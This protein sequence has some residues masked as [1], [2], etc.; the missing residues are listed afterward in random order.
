M[1]CEFCG[2]SAWGPCHG[3]RVWYCDQHGTQSHCFRCAP[4]ASQT[5]T[6][7]PWTDPFGPPITEPPLLVEPELEMDL[8]DWETQRALLFEDEPFV[9]AFMNESNPFGEQGWIGDQQFFSV[10]VEQEVRFAPTPSNSTTQPAFFTPQLGS[11]FPAQSPVLPPQ[12]PFISPQLVFTSPPPQGF[13]LTSPAF[14]GP[15][16]SQPQSPFGLG[17]GGTPQVAPRLLARGRVSTHL[18]EVGPCIGVGTWNLHGLNAEDFERAGSIRAW[19]L[20][21]VEEVSTALDRLLGKAGALGDDTWIEIAGHMSAVKLDGPRAGLEDLLGS[22]RQAVVLTKKEPELDGLFQP[23][24]HCRHILVHR[25]VGTEGR[26]KKI[27]E[28]DR[29]FDPDEATWRTHPLRPLALAVSKLKKVLNYSLI[30][31]Q[32]RR[33]F[34]D[35]PWLDVM[36]L[37]EVRANGITLLRR[38]IEAETGL[39]VASGPLIQGSSG[40]SLNQTEY[41]PIVYRSDRLKL[42]DC[43]AA[44]CFPGQP[45]DQA[46]LAAQGVHEGA[47]MAQARRTPKQQK[48]RR[49]QAQAETEATGMSLW[50]PVVAQELGDLVVYRGEMNGAGGASDRNVIWN[51]RAGVYRPIVVYVL[52]DVRSNKLVHVANVHTTP[53]TQGES[54]ETAR[55][56]DNEWYRAR[57]YE[58]LIESLRKLGRDTREYWL[59]G[60]DYYLG[61]ESRVADVP[62]DA[63]LHQLPVEAQA[64]LCAMW[65]QEGYYSWPLARITAPPNYEKKVRLTSE[66]RHWSEW[67]SWFREEQAYAGPPVKLADFL[68]MIDAIRRR[69]EGEDDRLDIHYEAQDIVRNVLGITF[70]KQLPGHWLISQAISGTN[71]DLKP[72]ALNE[73]IAQDPWQRAPVT[74]RLRVADFFLY[75]ATWEI[76]PICS[77]NGRM[78]LFDPEAGG[79]HWHDEE[80]LRH[81]RRWLAVS[82]HFPVGGMFST[83]PEDPRL[84]LLLAQPGAGPAR[85]P[86]SQAQEV[87]DDQVRFKIVP[88][89]PDGNCFLYCLKL[90]TGTNDSIGDMR[91]RLEGIYRV[92]GEYIG[93]D[94]WITLAKHYQATI[95]VHEFVYADG[96][97]YGTYLRSLA[98][99]ND[100][101]PVVHM[102]FI[103]VPGDSK[104]HMDLL[105]RIA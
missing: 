60:G 5:Q 52:L 9:D 22:I 27:E 12:G 18:D 44:G 11:P 51:K 80:D 71:S 47:L 4:T 20:A 62:K 13:P 64:E 61:A 98:P 72:A 7:S 57:E 56:S 46:L 68:F 76:G 102:T 93:I 70:Q 67:F 58:Q 53:G 14:T 73:A 101:H 87:G 28:Q 29:D 84:K 66:I 6:T 19:V 21:A 88:V 40:V 34:A 90:A 97:G 89:D 39:C 2:R 81:S 8:E 48:R 1:Q 42:R 36:V 103:H 77:P 43:Y 50:K 23:W 10:P 82:D 55:N 32:V 105:D 104:G 30:V 49:N 54:A 33:L 74:A 37:Q 26:W 17:S 35:N 15:S 38:V 85:P 96:P 31:R 91:R 92:D 94:G 99:I 24:A 25:Y 63:Y 95:V 59:M 41:Y 65:R 86:S 3:C 69:S 79:L 78:G 45:P 83:D 16:A 100:G 75:N